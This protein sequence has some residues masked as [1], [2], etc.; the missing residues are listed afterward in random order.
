MRSK[1]VSL[2]YCGVN[3]S[4]CHDTKEA[5]MACYE[6]N[7]K[8]HTQSICSVCGRSFNAEIDAENCCDIDTLTK[9]LEHCKKVL[10]ENKG[11]NP[12]LA[13]LCKTSIER[14]KARLEYSVAWHNNQSKE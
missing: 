10:K 3:S 1:Q 7:A 14:C 13:Q 8:P 9:D 5:A 6:A 2:W 4:C 12:S 11:R